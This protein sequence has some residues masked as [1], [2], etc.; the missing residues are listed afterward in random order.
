M[1]DRY[2]TSESHAGGDDLAWFAGQAVA[3][4]P[5]LA[6]DV[7]C[8]GGFSTRALAGAGHRVVGTDLTP[9][10]LAAARGATS[11]DLPVIWAAAAAEQLPF[12]DASFGLVGCR[13]APHHFGSPSRFAR[14]VG[15]ILRP[16]GTFL[17][18]DTTVPWNMDSA[19]WIDEV[20]RLRDPSHVMAY[21]ALLW[22][23][24]IAFAGLHRVKSQTLPKRHHLEAWLARS[25]CEGEAADEVRR[26]MR[27]APAFI[28]GSID[29]DENGQP[30]AF[31]DWK[32][33]LR[34]SKPPA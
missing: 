21:P 16:G 17:L 12:A 22:A 8:G 32:L 15:R 23:E 19:R 26:R 2:A 34:A 33:C 4:A 10:A 31:T 14:E 25:G 1:A 20:E 9:E 3:V 28:A 27:D 24:W 7:A 13:I 11:P 5:T 6:L 18:V 29:F 30:V